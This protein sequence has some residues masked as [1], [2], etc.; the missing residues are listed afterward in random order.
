[1]FSNQ[2]RLIV[3]GQQERWGQLWVALDVVVRATV[4]WSRHKYSW[5]ASATIRVLRVVKSSDS[6]FLGLEFF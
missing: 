5:S 1:M 2:D 6:A 3:R 4:L